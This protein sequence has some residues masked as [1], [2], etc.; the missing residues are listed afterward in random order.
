MSDENLQRGI[1][2]LMGFLRDI[3]EMEDPPKRW[4]HYAECEDCHT[5]RYFHDPELDGR[6]AICPC[7]GCGVFSQLKEIE[8]EEE[9]E[10]EPQIA[11]EIANYYERIFCKK[12]APH[13]NEEGGIDWRYKPD[14]EE[15]QEQYVKRLYRQ[16]ANGPE[17]LPLSF[18]P[19]EE[20]IVLLAIV[21]N[22][23]GDVFHGGRLFL[24]HARAYAYQEM[25]A[26]CDLIKRA[27]DDLQEH[28]LEKLRVQADDE[29]S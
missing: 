12:Q 27:I 5:I 17:K 6:L 14:G 8:R 29:G 9:K 22:L 7:L 25:N 15:T 4:S 11:P 26:V 3:G 24:P 28:N 18:F 21:R 19:E 10:E 13:M 20:M 1:R 16:A 23:I 2:K